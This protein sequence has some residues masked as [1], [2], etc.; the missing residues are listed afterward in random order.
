M[1]IL[2]VGRVAAYLYESPNELDAYEVG[3]V[4]EMIKTHWI[5][6]MRLAAMYTGGL[7]PAYDLVPWSAVAVPA[8]PAGPADEGEQDPPVP[9]GVL[10]EQNTGAPSLPPSPP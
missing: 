5:A 10:P 3:V 2:Y 9:G 1:C 8:G 4:A 7:G 6:G